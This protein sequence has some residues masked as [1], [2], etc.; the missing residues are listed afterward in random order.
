MSEPRTLSD[1][2]TRTVSEHFRPGIAQAALD[3]QLALE[4]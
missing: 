2:V 1:Q 3:M 4:H